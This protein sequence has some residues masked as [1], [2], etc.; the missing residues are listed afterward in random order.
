MSRRG[1]FGAA[2]LLLVAACA[3]R[4]IDL[5]DVTVEA[6]PDANGNAAVAVDVVLLSQSGLGEQMAKLTAADWFRRKAQLLR[7]NPDGMRVLSWELIPGQSTAMTVGRTVLDAYVF[8]AYASPGDHRTRLT[9]EGS[10]ARIKLQATDFMVEGLKK[11][12]P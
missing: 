10:E 6:A 1:V 12:E 7:D 5:S 9:V 4:M 11:K 8:A 3:P 2:A